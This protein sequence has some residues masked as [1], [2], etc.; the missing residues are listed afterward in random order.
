[1]RAM[2]TVLRLFMKDESIDDL[3]FLVT[4]AGLVVHARVQHR[5]PWS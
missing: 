5:F 2:V 3:C 4:H 1:V